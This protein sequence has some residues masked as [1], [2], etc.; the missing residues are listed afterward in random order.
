MRS[1]PKDL[2]KRQAD[3]LTFIVDH[4]S[5]KGFPPTVA[6]IA[7]EFDFH[8]PN[9]SASHLNALRKK[10]FIRIHPRAS[11]GIE[12]LKAPSGMPQ[13]SGLAP[14]IPIVGRVAAGS[15]ILAE[16]QIEETLTLDPDAFR[17]RP[18]YLLRV[19]G[20]SMT[21]LGIYEGDLVAVH[22]TQE[23]RNGD[24]VVA[25]V[26]G[27][28]TVKTLRRKSRKAVELEPANPRYK[29]ISVDMDKDEFGIEGLCVGVLRAL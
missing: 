27:D 4:L 19:H 20:D 15:P 13:P 7:T 22:R 29:T 17:K 9:A 18:D 5:G 6:E 25:N 12:I 3:I 21:G 10:G 24:I 23:V 2:T 8:S 14:S 28:V 1:L 11:R 26:N 16:E